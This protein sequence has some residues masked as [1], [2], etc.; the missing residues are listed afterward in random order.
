LMLVHF[1]AVNLILLNADFCHSLQLWII[2]WIF[3]TFL[4]E[5]RWLSSGMLCHVAWQQTIWCHI[6]EDS[7]LHTCHHENLKCHL[8]LECLFNILLCLS[9]PCVLCCVAFPGDFVVHTVW[10]ASSNKA[11]PLI[12]QSVHTSCLHLQLGRLW[13]ACVL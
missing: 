10:E 3:Y 9:A 7:N 6:P 4:L 8:L 12:F 13:A 11:K 5:W 1:W 2:V